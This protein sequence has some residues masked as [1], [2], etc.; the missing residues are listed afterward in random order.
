MMGT[1]L[2]IWSL[3][4]PVE[5]RRAALMLLLVVVMA[6]LETVGV[7]SIIP[8][9]SVIVRP[10]IISEKKWLL[11]FYEFFGFDNVRQFIVVLG[12]MSIFV[13]V[14]SSISKTLI[15]HVIN[16][17]IHLERYSISTRLLSRYITQPYEFF[18]KRNGSEL[19]KN[20]LS[21]VDMLIFNL[22][23]P[24]GHLI[25]QSFVIAAMLLLVFFYDPWI[26]M[27]T[28]VIIGGLYMAI[29]RLVRQR[30][31]IAGKE[32]VVADKDR[33]QSCSEVFSG[34]RDI[35]IS[36]ASAVYEKRFA[37]ATRSYARH[38]AASET[39][40]QTPL[41]LV[42]AVGYTGLIVIALVL[43]V[44][45]DDV[46]HVLP[47]L[48]MYGFAAYRLL[49]AVQIIY[50]GVARLR[51]AG[52]ALDNICED[53][54]LPFLPSP[55]TD[56]VM[57]PCL[58]IELRDVGYSYPSASEK[59]VLK[60]F[61]MIIQ[62]NTTVG[63]TGVSGSGKST[64]MDLLLGLQ[65]PKKGRLLVDG[66]EITDGNIKEWQNAIGYVSQY[67]Y[68]ADATVAENIAFGVEIESIDINAVERAARAAQIHDFIVNELPRGYQTNLGERGVRLSGGQRQRIGI[69]RALYRDPPVLFFDEATS[70]LD[71]KTENSVN[72]AISQLKGQKTIIVIAH[73]ASALRSCQ[74]TID[75]K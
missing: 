51:F 43:L 35:K 13:I 31:A 27:G 41:Y 50:R 32:V 19:S 38:V 29:Y 6:G 53:L 49:P 33:Y 8:F 75:L 71:E 54:K 17:F 20:V 36:G 40:S 52:A 3:F 10:E 46:G 61:N 70:A 12:S 1:L 7:L 67:I 55:P 48:G 42:E 25:A 23:Q 28:V 22:I 21:E 26:A 62:I 58:C 37:E 68:I 60:G 47:A 66:V 30:L 5:K 57:A 64:L 69:A 11:D 24:V 63:I 9:L 16:R 4:T 74:Y 59:E 2:K 39:L 15:Y 18:L 34:I 65:L 73:K 14:L 44:R 45:S 56:K 72:L